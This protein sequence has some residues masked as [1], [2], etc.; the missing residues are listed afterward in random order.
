[1]ADSTN[2]AS[3]EERR[4]QRETRKLAVASAKAD[5]RKFKQDSR[6]AK[7]SD[8]RFQKALGPWQKEHDRLERVT[9][10]L[11]DAVA[12]RSQQVGIML[13]GGEVGL[14]A[15][16]G[17]LVEARRGP[18]HYQGRSSG[19]SVPIGFGVRYRTGS[20]R[21]HYVQGKEVLTPID[22]GRIVITTQRVVFAGQKQT[23]EWR[24]S[25]LVAPSGIN[26]GKG[27]LLSVSNRQ[28]VSGVLFQSLTEFDTYLNAGF[29][30]SQ[31]NVQAAY[32]WSK[33]VTDEHQESR[34]QLAA[35]AEQSAP[36]NGSE[37]LENKDLGLQEV[38]RDP[39]AKQDPVGAERLSTWPEIVDHIRAAVRPIPPAEPPPDFEPG[40]GFL[41]WA[42]ELRRGLDWYSSEYVSLQQ[43]RWP[44]LKVSAS[45]PG[46]LTR[47]VLDEIGDAIRSLQD[48]L[49]RSINSTDAPLIAK[50]TRA[51]SE[52]YGFFLNVSLYLGG[53]D[54]QSESFDELCRAL[55]LLPRGTISR[56]R[57]FSFQLSK[58]FE[59][60][61]AD[62]RA[63]KTPPP[64]PTITLT[65]SIDDEALAEIR[66]ALG[67][68]QPQA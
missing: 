4:R 36:V 19:V 38:S 66:K 29:V 21:G 1:M 51:V 30:A 27:M 65:P 32:L 34:P 26:G 46:D 8:R 61:C 41:Y 64:P 24:F 49:K 6:E 58:E 39:V 23:R 2:R 43:G 17:S 68:S 33:Q 52:R 48:P 16:P 18:G 14:W 47:S 60:Y 63:G 22:A 15:M 35:K 45:D 11:A 12:G 3:E 20:S 37:L 67:L 5:G 55:S 57:D 9:Q 53:A 42:N 25:K 62:L 40:W 59:Q 56:I 13:T 50:A 10:V 28:K 31:S 44:T 7:K 54:S